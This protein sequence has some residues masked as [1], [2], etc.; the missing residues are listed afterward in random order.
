MKLQIF[1]K[2]PF[3]S[4]SIVI[5]YKIAKLNIRKIKFFN[6]SFFVVLSSFVISCIDP[7]PPEFNF[8]SDIILINGIRS[9]SVGSSNVTV[10]KTLI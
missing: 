8:Q 3:F 7:L 9:T 1:F 2:K 5:L 4:F 6:K 10:E